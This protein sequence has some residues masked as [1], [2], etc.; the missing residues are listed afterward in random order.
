MFTF[1]NIN[2]R[3]VFAG[4]MVVFC[5]LFYIATTTLHKYLECIQKNI[6]F[7]FQPEPGLKLS[8]YIQILTKETQD[9]TL[10]ISAHQLCDTFYKTIVQEGSEICHINAIFGETLRTGDLNFV[11]LRK[12]V[13]K[14]RA[15]F[16]YVRENVQFLEKDIYALLKSYK[17]KSDE[18]S[19]GTVSDKR[20]FDY[21]DEYLRIRRKHSVQV[22]KR[23]R[24]INDAAVR[25]DNDAYSC[26][27]V[28]GFVTAYG[29]ILLVFVGNHIRCILIC[30]LSVA[31][32]MCLI[33][34]NIQFDKAKEL[35]A[36]AA[37]NEDEYHDIIKE[38]RQSQ[39]SLSRSRNDTVSYIVKITDPIIVKQASFLLFTFTELHTLL[40]SIDVDS[41]RMTSLAVSLE[42]S[43]RK[44]KEK[45]MNDLQITCSK[46]VRNIQTI[47]TVLK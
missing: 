42:E 37:K 45:I 12:L 36:K 18:K 27:T 2:T 33:Y 13:E 29:V 43:K 31:I 5:P 17:R 7:D 39:D 8:G 23:A 26:L 19:D 32:L 46:T 30:F 4:F 34:V 47:F 6:I 21:F 16:R 38:I 35:R 1:I 22:D 3:C 10:V 24:A 40:H 25:K 14:V 41:K 20:Y 15:Q 44:N 11:T 28:L 9:D